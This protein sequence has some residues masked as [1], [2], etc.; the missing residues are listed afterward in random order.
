MSIMPASDLPDD[1]LQQMIA[2]NPVTKLDDDN[3]RTCPVRLS[4]PHVFHPS[5]MEDDKEPKFSVTLLFPPNADLSVLDA[6]T[7]EVMAAEHPEYIQN[8]QWVA[9]LQWPMRDQGE[10]SMKLDGYMPGAKFLTASSKYKPSVV[11]SR[12]VPIVDEARVYPGVWALACINCYGYNYKN[13]KRGVS[14][15]LQSLMI[16]ADD[17]K[18][19]GGGVD[20]GTAFGGANVAPPPNQQL[21]PHG[22]APAAPGDTPV[23]PAG[24]QAPPMPGAAPPMP[25]A[26]A[27]A[28]QAA[29]APA[30][31]AAPPGAPPATPAGYAPPTAP[32]ASPSSAPAVPGMP[33]VPQQ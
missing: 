6:R 24:Y 11:D 12:Q 30:P 23:A 20:P 1:W 17:K 4:F 14:W 29:P 28:P 31:A 15:G 2:Q 3:F 16:I 13:M 18:L 10:K 32:T 33:P 26:Q 7:A 27:A 25:G 8:G 5:S 19:G 9:G 21:M 22:N